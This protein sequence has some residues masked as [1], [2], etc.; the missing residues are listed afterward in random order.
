[1]K[2]VHPDQLKHYRRREPLNNTWVLD[3][4][5][6]WEPT[7][8][9]SPILED[10]ADCDLGLQGLFSDETRWGAGCSLLLNSTATD[11][12][13]GVFVPSSPS[14][15]NHE[16]G[17]GAVGYSPPMSLLVR[18]SRR[19]RKALDLYGTWKVS[20]RTTDSV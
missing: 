10:S 6:H 2:V 4:S 12:N 9:P 3:Q 8:V 14:H 17:G 11:P 15:V 16:D 7:E 20:S 13:L 5:K 19:Q 1:M 18:R